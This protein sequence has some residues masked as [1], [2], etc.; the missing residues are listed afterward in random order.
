[1]AATMRSAVRVVIVQVR[2]RFA[3]GVDSATTGCHHA[4]YAASPAPACPRPAR[5][6]MPPP[7]ARDARQ[8]LIVIEGPPGSAERVTAS[9]AAAGSEVIA[10]FLLP[11]A[12][13]RSRAAP[14][15]VCAGVVADAKGAAA[16][17]LAALAGAGVVIE[18]TAERV[19]IDRLVDDLRHLGPVEHRIVT[20]TPAEPEIP[21]EARAILGLLAEGHSL[22][23]AAGILGISRRTADRRIG[24]ARGAL[25]VT[26]TTE[27]IARAKALGM[28]GTPIR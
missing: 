6:A 15:L 20:E 18:A 27:A 23:E 13:E 12:R 21:R 9:L 10:G 5:D 11:V 7:A 2:H 24:E 22:G 25:G 3:T 19:T 14:P 17:L 1:M 16:A 8:P 4:A 26:R 28:L